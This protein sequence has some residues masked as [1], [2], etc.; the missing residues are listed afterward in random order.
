MAIWSEKLGWPSFRGFGWRCLSDASRLTRAEFGAECRI[1][2]R[3]VNE[4]HADE[5][6]A[7][8]CGWINEAVR[9]A[10][11]EAH[12]GGPRR[13][14][15][16]QAFEDKGDLVVCGF[17]HVGR[18]SRLAEPGKLPCEILEAT[19]A[20]RLRGISIVQEQRTQSAWRQ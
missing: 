10:E 14:G 18:R 8:A 19:L 16:E 3:L 6:A 20:Q 5:A 15:S 2:W 17:K 13:A 7:C 12:D 1:E 4:C 11:G 9:P